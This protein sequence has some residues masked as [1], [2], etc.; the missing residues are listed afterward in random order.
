MSWIAGCQRAQSR[1]CS[2]RIERNTLH[3]PRWSFAD[4]AI[5]FSPRHGSFDAFMDPSMFMAMHG[6]FGITTLRNNAMA[7]TFHAGV[8]F[9]DRQ[10]SWAWKV[11]DVDNRY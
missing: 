8:F 1:H 2:N 4:T 5:T 7:A 11:Q 6:V 3:L 10:K 9:R